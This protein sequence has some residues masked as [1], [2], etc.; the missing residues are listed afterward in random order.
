MWINGEKEVSLVEEEKPR[1][2]AK[3]KKKGYS[4]K[5]SEEKYY[6]GAK[7]WKKELKRKATRRQKRL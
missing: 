3:F 1:G 7:L 5:E 2:I 4:V 6:A